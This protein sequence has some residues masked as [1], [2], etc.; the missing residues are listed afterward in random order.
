MY[1]RAYTVVEVLIAA[2]IFSVFLLGVFSL[3]NM[4][5]KMYISGSWKFNKQKEGERF[6]QVLKERIE[7]ASVPSKFEKNDDKLVMSKASNIGYFVNK[8]GIIN[9]KGLAKKQYIS[10]FIVSKADKSKTASSTKGLILYHTLFCEPQTNGLAKLCLYVNN[11]ENDSNYMAK[12]GEGCKFPPAMFAGEF[13]ADPS[14]Y[15]FPKSPH[16]YELNDI[17]S[18][19]INNGYYASG[20][21]PLKN[22]VTGLIITMECPKHPETTLQMRTQAKVDSSL[23]FVEVDF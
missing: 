14:L 5:S 17:K 15:S 8:N 7:Q 13:D 18:I 20:T 3:F 11:K 10:E 1:K 21:A 6:L 22:P 23:K 19:E 9:T 16:K 2:A 4:G 12:N